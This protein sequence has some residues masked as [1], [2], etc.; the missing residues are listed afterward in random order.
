MTNFVIDEDKF[1]EKGNE[2]VAT[3]VVSAYLSMGEISIDELEIT[4][5][6]RVL[7]DNYIEDFEK[8][9]EETYDIIET[10]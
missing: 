8:K 4:L 9:I 2:D 3:L 10:E 1:E 5:Y 7:E 6:N